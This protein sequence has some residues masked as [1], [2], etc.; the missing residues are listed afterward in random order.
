MLHLTSS[1]L[2][3]PFYL[4]SSIPH[5]RRQQRFLFPDNSDSDSSEA[6]GVNADE[7]LRPAL[8][9]EPLVCGRCSLRLPLEADGAMV[10]L[11]IGMLPHR[12]RPGLL[13]LTRSPASRPPIASD[14][15]T[16]PDRSVHGSMPLSISVCLK[17]SNG[18]GTGTGPLAQRRP[19]ISSVFTARALGTMWRTSRGCA[20]L[21][22]W[23]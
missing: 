14:A 16:A 1:H 11:R 2:R 20:C 9:P 10:V 5:R 21:A 3:P 6:G 22:E 23:R 17:P 7:D 12:R 4:F 19:L 18:S 8:P 15:P 13:G